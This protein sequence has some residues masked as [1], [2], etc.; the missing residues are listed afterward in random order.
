RLVL[1]TGLRDRRGAA[2]GAGRGDRERDRADRRPAG[3]HDPPRGPDRRARRGPRRGQRH[4]RRA[5]GGQ[6]H[7]PRDRPF[8]TDRTGG[9]GV[10]AP[11]TTPRRP[12]PP[13]F[14]PARMMAAGMP[15]EK[16]MDFK[17]STRRL[18]R[19]LRPDRLVVAAVLTLGTASVALSVI[20]PKVLGRA[21]DIIFAGV[22]GSRL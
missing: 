9:S 15:V 20:G 5:D 22:V 8:P 17:G 7:L 10:T 21:T 4:A 6:P 19:L 1:R 11:T 16:A 14:G 18:L 3:Q 13:A 2:R 12:P